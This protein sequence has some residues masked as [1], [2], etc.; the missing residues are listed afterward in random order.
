MTRLTPAQRRILDSTL[1]RTREPLGFTRPSHAASTMPDP[2]NP[3]RDEADLNA[4]L[5]LLDKGEVSVLALCDCTKRSLKSLADLLESD[6]ARE[7]FANFERIYQARQRLLELRKKFVADAALVR[8]ASA[9]PVSHREAESVRKSANKIFEEH[10]Q[11]T[12]HARDASPSHAHDES[13]NRG[14]LANKA[15]APMPRL[16]EPVLL[17]PNQHLPISLPILDFPAIAPADKQGRC[18]R[19]GPASAMHTLLSRTGSTTGA[20]PIPAASKA[21]DATEDSS[22]AA[23]SHAPKDRDDPGTR[24]RSHAWSPS[25]SPTTSSAKR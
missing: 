20:D 4:M 13:S 8:I 7:A 10:R 6:L 18:P 3:N 5:D 15:E 17:N 23:P 19:T 11:K 14:V 9:A 25:G 21:S 1:E 12:R 22:R 2:D 16:T 24:R